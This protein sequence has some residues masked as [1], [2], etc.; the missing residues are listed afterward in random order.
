MYVIINTDTAWHSAAENRKREK[1]R[2]KKSTSTMELLP[3]VPGAF[4]FLFYSMM[5]T[6]N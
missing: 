2:N 6:L 5:D 4:D 3:Y 1:E